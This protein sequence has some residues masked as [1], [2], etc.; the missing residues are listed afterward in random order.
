MGT[1]LPLGTSVSSEWP[2]DRVTSALE[3]PSQPWGQGDVGSAVSMLGLEK[4]QAEGKLRC[5]PRSALIWRRTA[6]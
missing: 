5:G 6:S 1:S 4:L 3:S 2:V